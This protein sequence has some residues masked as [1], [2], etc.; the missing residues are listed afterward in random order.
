MSPSQQQSLLAAYEAAGYNPQD[1]MTI[2]RNSLPQYA[3]QQGGAG[4]VN[5]WGR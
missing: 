4:R 3:G 1:V 5:L 2:F